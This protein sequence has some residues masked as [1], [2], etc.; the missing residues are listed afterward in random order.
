M[1]WVSTL[2]YLQ[3]R[4]RKTTQQDYKIC[5]TKKLLVQKDAITWLY[6]KLCKNNMKPSDW[7]QTRLCKLPCEDCRHCRR[8][9][10]L[11]LKTPS[12]QCT[13]MWLMCHHLRGYQLHPSEDQV[14]GRHVSHPSPPFS[15][16]LKDADMFNIYLHL[17][18]VHLHFS[19]VLKK[20]K[21]WEICHT[22]TMFRIPLWHHKEANENNHRCTV[23]LVSVVAWEHCPWEVWDSSCS[24]RCKKN[25]ISFSAIHGKGLPIAFN[26]CNAS[27]LFQSPFHTLLLQ[28]PVSSLCN[29][30]I[31]ITSAA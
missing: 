10:D 13:T 19:L 5:L 7:I 26:H 6:Q 3:S 18:H 22:K 20:R 12:R 16:F 25:N 21:G 28:C 9:C 11:G 14:C 31:V 23:S 15:A 30:D 1:K 27:G 29:M 4:S 8:L 2:K 24:H 17:F